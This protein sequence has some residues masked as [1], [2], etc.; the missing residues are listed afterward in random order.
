[1][2]CVVRELAVKF[3]NQGTPK[4]VE[5]LMAWVLEIPRGDS[6]VLVGLEPFIGTWC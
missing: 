3:N 2:Q 1:M 4:K 6:T 5:F